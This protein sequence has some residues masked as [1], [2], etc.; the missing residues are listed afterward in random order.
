MFALALETSGR[1]GSVA[2]LRHG[3]LLGERSY[4]HGLHHATA[5][6][7]LLDQLLRE[8][9]ASPAD[10]AEVYVSTGPGSFTGLRVGVMIAKSLSFATGAKLVAVPSVRVLAE[11]APDQARHVVVVLD[12][13]RGQV[14]T[15]TFDRSDDGTL[16]ETQPARLARLQDVLAQTPR[17][18]HVLGEGVPYHRDSI[19]S[20]V[21]VCDESTWIARASVVASVGQSMAKQGG[22][23]DAYKITPTYIRLPEAEEKRLI[24]QGQLKPDGT[25]L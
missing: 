17:P 1:S 20:D 7:P 14:F 21:M 5:I 16:I 10:V 8:H 9:Q 25:A 3:R 12:A 23:V 4:P 18:V 6:V 2:L 22:Y 11:N 15:A 24:A 13:K 19:E